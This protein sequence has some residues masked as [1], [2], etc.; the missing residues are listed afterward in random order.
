[1]TP[2]SARFASATCELCGLPVLGR[3]VRAEAADGTAH[4]F[5]CQGCKRV[6][7][8]AA[9]H[10]LDSLLAGPVTTRTRAADAAAR[11]AAAAA[12][13]GAR[14]ETFRVDGMWC[15]SCSLVLEE[16]LLELPG[17]LDAEVSYAASLARITYD[18]SAV[19]AADASARIALLGY[20]AMSIREAPSADEGQD[21]QDLFLR[22]F[23]G[24]AVS[25]WV[26]WLTIFLLYPAFAQA[27]YVGLMGVELFVGALSLVV[28]VYSGWPFLRGA[29]QA[30]RVRRTTMDTLVVV[31]TW[32]AWL[33][34][35]YAA[36]TESGGT[37][38]ESA[39][40]ITVI[41]LLGRLI[42]AFARR[43][44]A[45]ALSGLEVGAQA[46]AWR[47][48]DESAAFEAAE[49]VSVESL[50]P[51]DAIAV[52]AGER[53]AADGVVI[54]G[55]SAID[56]ARL[57]GEAAPLERS[58]G[59][60]V[61]AGTVNLTDTLVVR[62][63]RAGAE[64]LSGR[65]RAIVEDAAFAKAH[66]QRLADA[67]AGVF[68]PLVFA[69]AAATLLITAVTGAGFDEA[70]TRSV[71][72]LVVACPCALGLATPL[73]VVNAV[74][75]ASR[76]GLLVRGGIV[77][78]RADDVAVV[79]FDKTGTLT[80]G[81]LMLAATVPAMLSGIDRARM[82]SL[83]AAV[84][85]GSPHPVAAAIADA[86]RATAGIPGLPPPA[87]ADSLRPRPGLGVEGAVD[88]SD[89][90]VG[91]TRLME[92]EK[93]SIPSRL[94]DEA[95]AGASTGNTVVWVA[96][97]GDLLGGIVLSDS[98]RP[99]AS[100]AI[101]ALRSRGLVVTL[102]SGDARGTSDAVAAALGIVD[103]RAEVLPNDKEQVVR[104][105]RDEFGPVVFVGDGINDAPALTAADLAVAVGS[106]SDVAL[107][108]SDVVLLGD[109]AYGRAHPDPH[110]AAQEEHR[111]LA[112]LPYLLVLAA[113][114]RRVISQNLGWALTYNLVAIPLA[115]AGLLTP[116]AAAAAMAFSSVAVV[117]NSLRLR[118]VR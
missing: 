7:T 107:E 40:M 79:A 74:S 13:A 99:E 41:V 85:S 50:E 27:H 52:R 69:V 38:F 72:V 18:P 36:L 21:I 20:R 66:T 16:A 47:L 75:A 102:V 108:A 30:A 103:V 73:A 68:T 90:L 115:V 35:M 100:A 42:E 10:G 45:Q 58:E 26:T 8:V 33:Y 76:R 22:F 12:L 29:I 3:P 104:E 44:A 116:I 23:V 111:P 17:V 4:D 11:K 77:L 64:T 37:Y 59:E 88:G 109:V 84:E 48:P 81:R 53:L 93:V 70:I 43:S 62:I 55:S 78:E 61:F 1:M 5:C 98:P 39:A 105:L 2:S 71:A 112:A 32:T 25:M 28:L 86:A 63:S 82:L 97:D 31:G 91:S 24:V 67:L 46:E 89:V 56:Q 34:S 57:T 19:S 65:I 49:R 94:A 54:R 9:E 95:E 83:A 51:G 6:W 106:A 14:R 92:V 101:A 117:A 60:E 15:S 110:S 114:S 80:Q 96:C 113:R 87:L 118:A